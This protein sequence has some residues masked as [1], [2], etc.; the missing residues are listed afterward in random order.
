MVRAHPSSAGAARDPALPAGLARILW[1]ACV[2]GEE[3]DAVALEPA[4]AR[5]GIG[6]EDNNG[7]VCAQV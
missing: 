3:G 2:G 1:V 5:D 7:A 6:L 4:R